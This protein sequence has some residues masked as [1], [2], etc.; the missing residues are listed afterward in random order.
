MDVVEETVS[1]NIV[2][3][4]LGFEHSCPYCGYKWVGRKEVVKTCTRCKT[5]LDYLGKDN[6]TRRETAAINL[7]AIK[8]CNTGMSPFKALEEAKRRFKA[9]LEV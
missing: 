5:R 2:S 9:I 7:I 6:G 3:K 8:L 4:R 1:A